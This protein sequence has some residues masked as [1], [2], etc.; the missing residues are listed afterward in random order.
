MVELL[1]ASASVFVHDP[2]CLPGR[3]TSQGR[4]GPAH[5]YRTHARTRIAYGEFFAY[6]PRPFQ[7]RRHSRRRPHRHRR[8]NRARRNPRLPHRRR[9]TLAAAG[10]FS[11][12][13]TNAADAQY[14]RSTGGSVERRVPEFNTNGGTPLIL[15][16]SADFCVYTSRSGKYP[17]SIHLLLSTLNATKP[18]LAALAYYAA[19][20][21]AETCTGGSTRFVLLLATRRDR[22]SSAASI[23]TAAH[24]S[25][26]ER[27]RP[28]TRRVHFPRPLIDRFV[29]S[30]LP[31][32]N[33][34]LSRHQ[35]RK[36]PKVQEPI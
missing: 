9:S 13:D 28:P 31:T 21:R 17:S 4:T 3:P 22:L 23:P 33:H 1:R 12:P 14:C 29:R 26:E 16:G 18:T 19:F 6:E 11:T 30:V 34:N 5:V 20:L 8:R 24:G 15:S 7:R 27:R 36:S 10:V 32:A 25:E 35:P 2:N